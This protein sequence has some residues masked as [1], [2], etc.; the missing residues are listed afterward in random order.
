[1][2]PVA[3]LCVVGLAAFLTFGIW[4]SLAHPRVMIAAGIVTVTSQRPP[5]KSITL[6]TRDVEINRIRFREVELPGG[7]WIDCAGD[8][9]VAVRRAREDFW[10]TQER[11][12]K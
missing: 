3:L 4:Y 2:R 11:G 12:R 10:E 7:T 8:C 9:P 5:F 1:M 6:A